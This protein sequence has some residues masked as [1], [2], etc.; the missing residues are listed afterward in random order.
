V[1]PIDVD[2]AGIPGHGRAEGDIGMMGLLLLME[3]RSR[4]QSKELRDVAVQVDVVD[5]LPTSSSVLELWHLHTIHCGASQT[6]G[7][8]LG[9]CTHQLIAGQEAQLGLVLPG[10][11]HSILIA[12]QVVVLAVATVVVVVLVEQL[13]DRLQLLLHRKHIVGDALS[14][15]RRIFGVQP[16][17]RLGGRRGRDPLEGMEI[18]VL[19]TLLGR[20]TLVGIVGQHVLQQVQSILAAA[21][22]DAAQW[23]FDAVR[24]AEVDHAG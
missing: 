1:A 21:A 23:H 17:I 16:H 10:H 5:G 18:R 3:L 15:G 11:S 13:R 8:R 24:V 7:I 9:A 22:D 19:E 20:R 12:R 6:G 14:I 2:G 4:W